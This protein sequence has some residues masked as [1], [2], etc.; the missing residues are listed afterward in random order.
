MDIEARLRTLE[1]RYRG[2][3]SAT[4]AAK[5]NYIALAAAAGSTPLSIER[6]K[7]HW[8]TLDTLKRTIDAQMRRV[9]TAEDATN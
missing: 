3:S 5:A 9:E 2:V 6:A 4:A 1:F 7:S 8:Q